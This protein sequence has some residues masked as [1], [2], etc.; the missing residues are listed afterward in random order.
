MTGFPKN[1][2][3]GLSLP[4]IFRFGIEPVDQRGGRS[5]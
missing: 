1:H 4:P 3:G 5:D 2:V